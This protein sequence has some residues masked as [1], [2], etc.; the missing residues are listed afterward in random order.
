MLGLSLT[1]SGRTDSVDGLYDCT[2]KTGWTKESALAHTPGKDYVQ[3]LAEALK[4]DMIRLAT[5]FRTLGSHPIP[6]GF[7]CNNFDSSN[8]SCYRA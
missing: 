3:S 4:Q 8:S 6:S 2:K 7:D 1:M 5:G